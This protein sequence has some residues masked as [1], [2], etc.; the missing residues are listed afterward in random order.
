MLFLSAAIYD[1]R[2]RLLRELK[3]GKI[4]PELA[5]GKLL[6][7][8]PD[9]Y[10]AMLGMGRLRYEAGDFAGAQQHLWSAIK[11]HPAAS[12]PYLE[13]A[14]VLQ[15]E[16]ESVDLA[17]GLAD[18]AIRWRQDDDDLLRDHDFHRAGI[19]EKE[20][21]HFRNLSVA[22]R[23]ELISRAVLA[24]REAEP[25]AVT[26]RLLHLRLLEKM[27]DEGDLD[28]KTVDA[29]LAAGQ[30][31]VPLLVGVLRAWA[32]DLLG[33]EGDTAVR[34]A[35]ALLGESA[36]AAETPHLLAFV[37]LKDRNTGGVA[38]WALGRIA[39]RCPR[40]WEQVIGSIASG[41]GP[42]E[43][44][45]V[46]NQ[47]FCNRGLDPGGHLLELLIHDLGAM[48][49]Q[50]REAFSPHC[51][52]TWWLRKGARASTSAI[53]SYGIRAAG[54]PPRPAVCVMTCCRLLSTEA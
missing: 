27:R 12:F 11:T 29:L 43:R 47:I 14:R 2:Q 26:E 46:A 4:T 28:S 53:R 42:G 38:V 49:E 24:N 23:Q 34:N 20:L 10:V 7:L 22:T 50:D 6:E 45:A 16:P 3:A 1:S 48:A 5:F 9:D 30:P 54:S 8:D 51:L 17:N 13:L 41:L 36:S 39:Q 32:R 25:P 52:P 33:D 40:E 37:D 44:L 15:R 35:L 21:Q 31:M 18:L 19:K